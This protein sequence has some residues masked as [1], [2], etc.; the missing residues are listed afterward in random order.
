MAAKSSLAA[1]FRLPPGFFS[2]SFPHFKTRRARLALR[3]GQIGS[4]GRCQICARGTT[5][6]SQGLTA[7]QFDRS[8]QVQA[9]ARNPWHKEW[10]LA[11]STMEKLHYTP[12]ESVASPCQTLS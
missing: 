11:R 8:L 4:H 3:L 2:G 12:P 10:N 6:L 1:A 5:R 9:R 7:N